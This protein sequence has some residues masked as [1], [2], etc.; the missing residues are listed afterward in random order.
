VLEELMLEAGATKGRNL[1]LDFA[2][3]GRDLLEIDLGMWC[4]KIS[5]LHTV[6]LLL[7]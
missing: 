7:M 3:L 1:R 5:W 6:I 2:V 4:G